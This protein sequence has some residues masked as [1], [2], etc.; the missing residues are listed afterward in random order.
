M[1]AI[2]PSVVMLNVIILSAAILSI[3]APCNGIR[4]HCHKWLVLAQN[5]K[6]AD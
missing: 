3:V 1:S 6:D 5:W 4:T 2:I